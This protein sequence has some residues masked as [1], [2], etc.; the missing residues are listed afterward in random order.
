MKKRTNIATVLFVAGI[1]LAGAANAFARQLIADYGADP[2]TPAILPFF[3]TVMFCLNLALY[4][5][6]LLF[7]VRSVQQR[8]LPGR[9]RGYMI[10][11]ALCA[12]SVLLLRS[13]K[14]RMIDGQSVV[15]L[16]YAWYLYYVPMT[17]M[18]ALFLMMCI[19]VDRR[20]KGRFDERLLLI[21]AAVI[22]LLFLT[23]DLHFLA[24]RPTKGLFIMN[25]GDDTYTNGPLIYVYYAF[26]AVTVLI[27]MICLTRANSRSRRFK[28]IA[29]P[30]IFLLGILGLTMLNKALSLVQKPSMF[31]M[32]EIIAFGMIGVFESCIRNR[33]IQH[34]ENY[35]GFFGQMQFPAMIADERLNIVH[36]SAQR[37]NASPDQLRA[38]INAPVYSDEAIKLSAVGITAG[39]AFY[40]EDE[41]EL[42][43][44][45]ERLK[46]ANEL[47]AGENDL[48][49]AEN[50]LKAKQAQVDSRN[51]IYARIAESMLPY[52]RR[53]LQIIDEIDKDDL[54]FEAEI[55]RLN[56]LNAYIKRGSN[57]LLVEEGKKYI[58]VN[59]LKIAIE[60]F[61]RYLSYCGITANSTVT[62]DTIGR[63]DALSLFTAIYEV[64]A[65]LCDDT[66]MLSIVIDGIRLRMTADGAVERELPVDIAVKESGGL[67]FYSF[68]AGEGDA[69]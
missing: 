15:L 29:L 35:G 23:N 49:R 34:N 63:D 53:A 37:V 3:S 17:L 4:I 33:L 11:A 41:R 59:E 57:L 54:D 12:I 44:L 69:V 16:R 51:M 30:F 61:S 47:I 50:E 36:R 48:I 2:H 43:R 39:C 6:L 64:S 19:R 46:E 40:T 58:S 67:Y 55:A 60:E 62:G 56:L 5:F 8:L 31:M 28:A 32:P 10:A 26:C 20:G 14:Y 21:P 38:A 24:F 9:E 27:G 1:L 42:H 65:T 45:N 66:T 25:G 68:S 13:I 7:W 52:H 22:I 18:P